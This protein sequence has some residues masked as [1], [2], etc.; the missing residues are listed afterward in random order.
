MHGNGKRTINQSSTAVICNIKTHETTIGHPILHPKPGTCSAI[1]H[2]PKEIPKGSRPRCCCSRRRAI[3]V[4]R[5]YLDEVPCVLAVGTIRLGKDRHVGTGNLLF[6][7]RVHILT[8]GQVLGAAVV[9][10]AGR[11]RRPLLQHFQKR[12][13]QHRTNEK[14]A[15]RVPE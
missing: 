6:D 12:Q 5:A 15:P 9:V 3:K 10:G 2:R 11:R 14:A 1:G 4:Y 8:G 13:R 7:V